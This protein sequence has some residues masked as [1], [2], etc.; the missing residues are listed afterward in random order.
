MC[1]CNEQIGRCDDNMN[2][3]AHAESFSYHKRNRSSEAL[4]V[5]FKWRFTAHPTMDVTGALQAHG[6]EITSSDILS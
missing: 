4:Q 5:M 6:K 2:V 3:N 1:A